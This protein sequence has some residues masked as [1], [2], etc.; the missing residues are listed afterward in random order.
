MI[1][2]MTVQVA[3]VL[4]LAAQMA[5]PTLAPAAELPYRLEFE[6]PSAELPFV[7]TRH[8]E[9]SVADGNLRLQ[10]TGSDPQLRFNVNATGPVMVRA[11]ARSGEGAFGRMEV[12][13]R[14]LGAARF[15][16]NEVAMFP[17]IH[18]MEW[19]EYEF[20]LPIVEGPVTLR[21]DT[22]WKK[23]I[24]EFDYI[25]V[26]EIPLPEEIQSRIDALPESVSLEDGVLELELSP[27]DGR[28]DIEDTRTGRQWRIDA[29]NNPARIVDISRESDTTA[30][31]TLID[32]STMVEYASTF[33]LQGNGTLSIDLDT[34]NKEG[35][36]WALRN[37]PP[38]IKTRFD[39]GRVIFADRSSGT[40]LDQ[41]DPYY[42]NKDLLIY[43]NTEGTDMPFVGLFDWKSGDGVMILAETPADGQFTLEKDQRGLI[44]PRLRWMPSMDTFR[45]QR[46]MSYRF[47]PGEGYVGI[48][49]LYRERAEEL[50]LRKTLLEKKA[51]RPIV[52]RL[53]GG[54]L[55]W[56]STDP[57]DFIAE[58]RTLGMMR[59]AIGNATHGLRDRTGGL[60]RLNEMGY[61][62]F[63]YD[64]FSDITDG[65]TG[66]QTDDVDETAYH[67]RPGLGPKG[68][69]INPDGS[70]YSERSSAF[71]LRAVKTYVPELLERYGFNGRFIDVSM[72]ISLQEDW[73]PKHTFDRRQ[74]MAYKRE[75]FAWYMDQGLVM[76]TE[77]GNDWGMDLVDFTEGA[78]GS[79]LHWKRQG[80][81]Y[82]GGLVGPLSEDEYLPEWIKYGTGYDTSIPLWQLV[83]HDAVVSSWYWG[84]NPGIHYRAAP[85][86]SDRK[87][88]MNLLYGTMT[89]L[90]RDN[91]GYD[92]NEYRQR[93]MRSYHDTAHFQGAVAY[94]PMTNHR[95]LSRDMAV[96][97]SDFADG[98]SVAVNFSNEPRV[99]TTPKGREV[100]LSPL[101][102]WAEGPAILQTRTIED[103]QIIKRIETETFRQYEAEKRTSL[104][105]VELEG[106][107]MAFRHDEDHWQLVL[108]GGRHYEIDL[109]QLAGWS[110]D[111]EIS[112]HELDDRSRPRTA[113]H[114]TMRDE[115]LKL[116]TEEGEHFY[117]LRR[118]EPSDAPLLYPTAGE[119]RAGQR[120][121]ASHHNPDAILR[122]TVDGSQPNT[123][124]PRVPYNGILLNESST[125]IVRPFVNGLPMGS[126]TS[127]E[128]EVFRRLYETPI[129]R[130]GSEAAFINVPVKG[131]TRLRINVGIGGD[132]PWADFVDLGEP[133]LVRADGTTVSLTE[134]EPIESQQVYEEPTI[135]VRDDGGTLV[136]GGRVFDKGIGLRSEATLVYDIGDEFE[137]FT[138]YAGINDRAAQN[139]RLI[140]GTATIKVD[141]LP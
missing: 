103:G 110:G 57:E 72:A 137:R 56:G 129:L 132:F 119:L 54:A 86:I 88:L 41:R 107:F 89:L 33:T 84:D 62:T 69:W 13:W 127:E 136:V 130:S 45:Y 96:Q 26:V 34:E 55:I 27:Q 23:G 28:I 91:T 10:I 134:L 65:P 35:L 71:A 31:L 140:Q 47:S 114:A 118:V 92:W 99:Y 50:G 36:F 81:W 98:T 82:S 115:V 49:K 94:T 66:W 77:H 64:S 44:W 53:M 48:A 6:D 7:Y 38:S 139:A 70:R 24:F 80:N 67:A 85:W 121:R 63:D 51:E 125:L 73:H 2:M 15:S 79:P 124:S 93:F 131:G 37:W 68:G 138:T 4:A 95:F 21:L 42:G 20:P 101:G 83:Y 133:L 40:L 46:R 100:M 104:G 19:R 108:D 16:E 60:R 90:W 39:D 87:D 109:Q 59:A 106:S 25:E 58:A 120:I 122:Y 32:P 117:S 111:S 102:Y 78:A 1:G 8:V 76:G 75:T 22:G 126:S 29:A 30:V 18:D 128:Y 3:G 14:E 43:G 52:D 5:L 12:F 123:R 9:T 17:L 74:D 61:I 97:Q 116:E 141:I 113:L 112:L 11:R 135:D 105:G